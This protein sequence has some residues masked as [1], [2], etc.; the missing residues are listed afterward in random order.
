MI[1]T[2]WKAL[3]KDSRSRL[4][5]VKNR[6]LYLKITKTKG[7]EDLA[8]VV[9]HLP[10]KLQALSSKP[11]TTKK[12]IIKIKKQIDTLKALILGPARPEQRGLASNA[13]NHPIPKDLGSVSWRWGL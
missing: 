5:T 12:I 10:S 1:P 8:Q 3:V 7:S 6:R 11:H 2:A 13:D 4:A 9:N